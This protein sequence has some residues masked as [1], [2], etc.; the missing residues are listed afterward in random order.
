MYEGG[1]R[2]V[3]R[4][5]P[6]HLKLLRSN[7]AVDLDEGIE[8]VP[9]SSPASFS[10]RRGTM[11]GPIRLPSTPKGPTPRSA[12]PRSRLPPDSTESSSPHDLGRPAAN[13][14]KRPE[15]LKR[16]ETG[17]KTEGEMMRDIPKQRES[18]AYGDSLDRSDPLFLNF[19]CN[20][21]LSDSN[22][23]GDIHVVAYEGS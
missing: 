9:T 20:F 17:D 19:T 21:D 14:R 15:L 16:S 8:S 11:A 7:V 13:Q 4:E 10:A 2:T 5:K 18:A 12:P 1:V 22:S 3:G 6:A 23:E